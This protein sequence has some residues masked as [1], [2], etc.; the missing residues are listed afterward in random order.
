MK[1]ILLIITVFSLILQV[2]AQEKKEKKSFDDAFLISPNYTFQLP[3]SDMFHSYGFNQNLGMEVAY[4]F[5]QNFMISVEGNFLF[6]SKVKDTLHLNNLLTKQGFIIGKDGNLEEVNLSG[7]GMNI[8]AK[9]SKIINFGPKSPNSGLLLKFGVGFLDHKILIDVNDKNVPQ[10]SNEIKTGYDR[11]TSGIAFSQYIGLIKLE[12]KKFLNLSF[13]IEATE[14]I[15]QN[16]RPFD[17][18]T[19]Q[20]IDKTRFDVLIGFKLNWYLPVWMGKSSKE[21]FYYY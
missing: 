7:R 4:K 1:K 19:A 18:G 11:Y 5:G 6:G 20:K 2:S 21:E 16:R 14:G 12:K 13:G 9:F 8:M 3:M 17:F 10:L 15:T